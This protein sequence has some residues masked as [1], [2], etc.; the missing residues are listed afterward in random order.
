MTTSHGQIHMQQLSIDC[1]SNEI[2]IDTQRKCDVCLSDQDCFLTYRDERLEACGHFRLLPDHP[3]AHYPHIFLVS[4][5][6]CSC[7]QVSLPG[8]SREEIGDRRTGSLSWM[9]RSFLRTN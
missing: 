4:R 8:G 9:M 2:S 3:P 7:L 1:V 6:H 5:C